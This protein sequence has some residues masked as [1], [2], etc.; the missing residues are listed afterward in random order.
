[1]TIVEAIK[2]VFTAT[3]KPLTYKEIYTDIVKNELYEFNAKLPEAVV[4]SALR[5][6]CFGLSFSSASPVKHFVIDSKKGKMAK[7]YIFEKNTTKN[8]AIDTKFNSQQLNLEKLPEE[9]L[10][11]AYLEYRKNI[12]A[13]LLSRV[14]TTDPAFFERLVMDL[15]LSMG[16][17]GN[18]PN[19][20]L[21]TGTPGDGGID[22]VIK[23][24]QLGLD[25]IYIQAKR[26]TDKKIGRPDIQQFI[27]AMDNV[28]KGVFITT[29][30]FTKDAEIFAEKHQKSIILINGHLLCDLMLTRSVGVSIISSYNTF[31]IDSDYFEDK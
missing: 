6:H 14:L 5:R 17:G 10:Q 16:Y 13:A 30:L 18:L 26:Y 15:L 22:G 28:N 20:G 23:E 12:E 9:K 1:M 11:D 31:K 19:A 29:S 8:Q 21:V 7:Y 2:E 4:N 24:D 25:K 27:G 3:K